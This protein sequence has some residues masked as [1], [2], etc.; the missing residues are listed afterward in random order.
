MAL[1]K[2]SRRRAKL[3]RGESEFS[4]GGR[5]PKPASR[6]NEIDPRNESNSGCCEQLLSRLK[7]ER[8]RVFA[9]TVDSAPRG[10]LRP[11]W[12]GG[13][14]AILA[15]CASSRARTSKRKNLRSYE[16]MPRGVFFSFFLHTTCPLDAPAVGP[17]LLQKRPS[18]FWGAL[19]YVRLI[20]LPPAA[21]HPPACDT[22][23][24]PASSLLGVKK[25]QRFFLSLSC[26]PVSLLLLSLPPPSLSVSFVFFLQVSCPSLPPFPK[27]TL[28]KAG[29]S[30]LS[31]RGSEKRGEV[32]WGN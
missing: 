17:A 20:L 32:Y 25:P 16:D 6:K 3:S 28:T 22:D 9:P 14:R 2:R 5:K 24:A 23:A 19:C 29:W 27:H 12:G 10:S 21:S 4:E 13:G 15:S 11:R 1:A 31:S 30:L 26:L 18:S 7:G 8:G